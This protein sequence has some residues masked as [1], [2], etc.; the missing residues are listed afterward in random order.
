MSIYR[1]PPAPN[2]VTSTPEERRKYMRSMTLCQ[3]RD[4]ALHELLD[5]SIGGMALPDLPDPYDTMPEALTRL[6]DG[7]TDRERA[8]IN[9]PFW[10]RW[11]IDQ[12]WSRIAICMDIFLR[13]QM[14]FAQAI[15][16]CRFPDGLGAYM[17]RHAEMLRTLW[18]EHEDPER[19]WRWIEHFNATIGFGLTCNATGVEMLDCAKA[20]WQDALTNASNFL[21]SLRRRLWSMGRA[22][23]PVNQM[24]D[25]AEQVMT[26]FE[27]F[28]P[29]YLLMP[30][31]T[32]ID[33]AAQPSSGRRR[34]RV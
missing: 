4:L 31:L 27:V 18:Q 21:E 16:M 34:I 1:D 19:N 24:I 9:G 15:G 6:W 10:R 12:H 2:P 26:Q 8:L 29:D 3:A 33:R 13:H 11:P 30:L 20:T 32:N 17:P 7:F 25:A 28:A 14:T 22:K 5:P 23:A